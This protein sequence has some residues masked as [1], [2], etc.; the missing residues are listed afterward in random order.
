M[1]P[2]H[3]TLL[4]PPGHLLCRPPPSFQANVSRLNRHLCR[5]RI[6]RFYW[7]VDGQV[8]SQGRLI[9]TRL[10]STSLSIP[11]DDSPRSRVLRLYC[12]VVVWT[13]D[14][15]RQSVPQQPNRR[16]RKPDRPRAPPPIHFPEIHRRT[17]PPRFHNRN[18][19]RSGCRSGCWDDLQRIP[20]YGQRIDTTKD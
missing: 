1:G 8:W 9:R 13:L 20:A 2:F 10:A 15:Q 17:G 3:R 5:H 11:L 6:P 14:P 18:V 12:D 16:P 4:R 7:M 19:R